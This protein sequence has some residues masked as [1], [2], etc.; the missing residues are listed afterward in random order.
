MNIVDILRQQHQLLRELLQ[1]TESDRSQ[2]EELRRQMLVHDRNEE[3][4]FLAVLKKKGAVRDKA[5]ES[6]EKHRVIEW[7]LGTLSDFPQQDERWPIKLTVLA[8]FCRQQLD[9]QERNIFPEAFK[10][11]TSCEMKSMA[12]E[13]QLHYKQQL[14]AFRAPDR[15]E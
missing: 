4:A 3:A 6:S 12:E 8:E 2:F 10:H 7:M 15:A 9:E 13:Y 11:L 14:E 5:L 1:H